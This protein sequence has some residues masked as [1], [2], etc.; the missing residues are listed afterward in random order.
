MFPQLQGVRRSS[1]S[2]APLAARS[3]GLRPRTTRRVLDLGSALAGVIL[4]ACTS[5]AMAPSQR[6]VNAAYVTGEAASVLD[7]RGVF[8][9][10][11]PPGAEPFTRI[12]AERAAELAVA[13]ARGFLWSTLS[14]FEEVHGGSIDLAALRQCG[15]IFYAQSPYDL[16][17]SGAGPLLRREVGPEW[18]VA[19][20]APDDAP[21]ISYSVS[22]YA[23][24]LSIVD[25]R[26]M[27][28]PDEPAG[29]EFF[30]WGIPRRRMWPILPERAVELLATETGLRVSGIPELLIPKAFYAAQTQSLWKLTLEAPVQVRTPAGSALKERTLYV[31]WEDDEKVGEPPSRFAIYRGRAA[32]PSDPPETVRDGPLEPQGKQ[33]ALRRRLGVPRDFERVTIVRVAGTP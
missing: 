26:V 28:N 30:M 15:R 31:G 32:K 20:C 14:T 8:R 12:S 23:T 10:P 33:H 22:A 9:L 7:A 2:E 17:A 11:E 29:G 5:D 3:R 4:V 24:N 19:L 16:S 18:I 1:L 27:W 21:Q 13:H 25:G 6:G